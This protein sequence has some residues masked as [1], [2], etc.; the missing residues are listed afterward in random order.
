M[1]IGS[2]LS[3]FMKKNTHIGYIESV[4]HVVGFFILIGLSIFVA[5][6]DILRLFQ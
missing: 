6:Q 5:Y 1:T 3:L 4:A 2:F